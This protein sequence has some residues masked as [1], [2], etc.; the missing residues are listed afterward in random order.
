LLRLLG[1]AP[2]VSYT[3]QT[4]GTAKALAKACAEIVVKGYAV[5]DAEF[6]EGVRCVAAPI[7]TESGV[8]IG[9]IGISAPIL[10]FP[11]ERYQEVG[12]QVRAIAE[13]ISAALGVLSQD[14]GPVLQK[15]VV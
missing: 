8:I 14:D 6:Q 9:S 13:E 1:A 5:D 2:L 15:K 11:V 7:R 4:I 10:R 12:E 3:R